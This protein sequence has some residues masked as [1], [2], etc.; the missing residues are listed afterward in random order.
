MA[1]REISLGIEISICYD[2]HDWG[3]WSVP[4][5]IEPDWKNWYA[6]IVLVCLFPLLQRVGMDTLFYTHVLYHIQDCSVRL[7]D[8][9][10]VP[11]A[12]RTVF[13]PSVDPR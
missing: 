1:N 5:F 12:D 3:G 9:L 7:P 4:Q 11:V 10:S 2:H 13:A 8:V 6:T